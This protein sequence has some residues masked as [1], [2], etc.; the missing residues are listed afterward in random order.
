MIH[1]FILFYNNH[2][3]II[4]FRV[5]DKIDEQFWNT[6]VFKLC[7]ISHSDKGY[8]NLIFISF[9]VQILRD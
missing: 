7:N 2:I 4:Y 3:F 9:I 1:I 6:C 8:T 5:I